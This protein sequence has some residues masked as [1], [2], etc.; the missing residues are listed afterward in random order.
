VARQATDDEALEE[1]FLATLTRSPTS[2]E[3]AAAVASLSTSA[4]RRQAWS[5]MLWAL[6]N[7]REFITNH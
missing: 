4:D 3:R 2:D 1:L 6:I 7:T 5:D